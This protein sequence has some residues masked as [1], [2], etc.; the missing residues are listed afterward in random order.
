[1]SLTLRSKEYELLVQEVE[2]LA[3]AEKWKELRVWF[4]YWDNED[5]LVYKV[6]IWSKFFLP[7]YFRD[8]SPDFHLELIQRFFSN[9]NEYTA[10]PRGFSKT[11]ILQA[12]CGF[13]IANQLDKF[14]VL[15]EKSFTEASEVLFAIRDEFANNNLI[16]GVYGN[17]IKK[18]SQ[19]LDSDKSKDTQGDVFI[20]GVR[21]RAKGFDSP[22]R[23]LK[24]KEFRPTRIILDDVESDDHI[25]SVDQR[26]KYQS[27]FLQGI[28]P[29]LDIDC[30]V[31]VYGTILHN[32]SLLSSLI[33]QHKGKIF[34]AYD[35]LRPKETLLWESRWPYETLEKKREEMMLE[36]FGSSRF[37]QEFLNEAIDDERRRFR[38]EW[39]KEYTPKD[40]QSKALNRYITV[41]T[42]QS[43]N[44]GADWTGVTVVDWDSDNNWYIVFAK[45]Y[46]INLPELIDYIFKWWGFYKPAVIG[47]ERKAFEDQ[48]KPY[49]DIKAAELGIF[50]IVKELEDKGTRKYDR[51]L[52]ALEG[53]FEAGKIHFLKGAT[54]D[55]VLLKGELYDFP[56]GK[57]DDLADSLAYVEQLG[58]RPYSRDK[59]IPTTITEEL[60]DYRRQQGDLNDSRLGF[61]G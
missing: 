58:S 23:G 28:I 10:A 13:S 8:A 35:K 50:P 37:Y 49:L 6:I 3:N 59:K 7:N 52:G 43:K 9:R 24:A 57:F 20:N 22:I 38:W 47:V 54:D 40:I 39:F 25:N 48:I 60:K 15:I 16:K 42:A 14:I 17:L 32:D 51:I 36:G 1:M 30:Y 26:K 34:K 31:K 2:L 11:T 44:D 33:Q 18:D 53:R 19:G 55:Q 61:L 45:R 27:N 41:D 12:C 56:A 29:A 4:T 21:L 46:K 5:E